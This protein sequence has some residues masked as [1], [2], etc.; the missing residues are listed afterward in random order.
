MQ[1]NL[2]H[3]SAIEKLTGLKHGNSI[4][5]SGYR[6]G[7]D[8]RLG[9]FPSYEQVKEDLLLLAGNWSF[10]RLYDCSKH[11]ETVLNVIETEKLDFHIMLGVDMAAEVS[12]PN[13]PWGAHFD[14]EKLVENK[15]H[16][17]DEI[18]RLIALA[19]QYP[20][21][22]FSVSVGNEASVE[23]TDHMVPVDS[24]VNYVKR[25]KT[26]IA[27][28]V[29]FCENYVPWTNK[30]A[31]LVEVL[32]FI[33]IHTYPV[34]EFQNIDNA[35]EYTKN[36]Y[37]QVLACHPDK[38]IVI[39]EAGWTTQSNGQGIES[40]NAS[41]ELQTAYY[42]QLLEWTTKERILTFVFEAFD[43]PWKGSDDPQEPEKHWG[44]FKVDRKP[45]Q[46]MQGA[47]S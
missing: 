44:L 30:L 26:N 8:P 34:W 42:A 29:T 39:T 11:A 41:E 35:L 6:D 12:N 31:P 2:E 32:D 36:N 3:Q 19:A 20:K 24:L 47:Y 5:Y 38:P 43:E 16:N 17:S 15:R 13:C 45:K 40:W 21:S 23:W 7:Q 22:V 18:D 9:I 14:D 10:L 27:Q 37:H 46:V 33:S 25:I 1:N 28:P 4:C